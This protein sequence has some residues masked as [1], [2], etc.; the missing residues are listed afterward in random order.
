MLLRLDEMDPRKAIQRLFRHQRV[1]EDHARTYADFSTENLLPTA[2]G[3]GY[4]GQKA[5]A[6][7]IFEGSS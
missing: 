5:A 7:D 4:R 6:L 3:P 2:E 1:L